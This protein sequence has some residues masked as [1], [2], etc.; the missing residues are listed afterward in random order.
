MRKHEMKLLKKKIVVVTGTRAEYGILKPLL[1]K[2]LENPKFQLHLIVAG[3]HLSKKFGY[4]ISQIISDGFTISGKVEMVPQGDTGYDM[5]IALSR[6][7]AQFSNLFKKIR[8][9]FNLIL[10][11]RDEAF[12]AA[13]AAMHMNII[14][15][16]IGGGDVSSG[17]DE[18]MRHAITKISNIHITSTKDSTM[19][20]IKLGED[21]KY[22]F[23]TGSPT[24]DGIPQNFSPK[25]DILKKY[26]L[27]D[28]YFLVIQ[29]SVTTEPTKSKS[30]I[31]TTLKAIVKLGK[32]ALIIGP[33]SDAGH[34][35]IFQT[36]RHYAR[37]Y[38]FIK[39]HKNIPRDEYLSLLKYC[40]LIIG[41]S[42]SGIIDAPFFKKASIN[43][44]R[45]QEMRTHTTNVIN[46]EHD[47][48]SIIEG[49]KRAYSLQFKRVL[50]RCDKNLYG[51]G[52]ASEKI[53]EKLESIKIEPRLLQK[54][55]TY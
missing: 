55:I 8:P 37:K 45:R 3:M 34:E 24:I 19:R 25:S 30:Q 36:I 35:K 1:Q 43:I 48:N 9:D 38:D 33:N 50:D 23:H 40:D 13:I 5:S 11:D 41:N 14:N 7:I 17:I 47:V 54:K 42:S 10:G 16:H 53:V 12:A 20:I 22:I 32:D 15:V 39:F 28:G 2:I 6:G 31:E 52:R 44:G 21:K 51:D 49:V 29:H 27:R 18:Y 26:G 46:V 4:S